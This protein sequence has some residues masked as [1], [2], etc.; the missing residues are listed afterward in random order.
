MLNRA[1]IRV[2]VIGV[3]HLGRH[4]ARIYSQM[5]DAQLVWVADNSFKQRRAIGA[6]TGARAI[7]DYRIGLKEVD[8][9]TIATPTSFHHGIAKVCL[10]A[11][12]HCLVEKPLTKTST[13]AD[14]LVELARRHDRVL[15]VGHIERFNPALMAL[16]DV[17]DNPAFVTSE[18]ISPFSFRSGDV[19]V[20][21]DLMIHDLDIVLTL[22]KSPVIDVEAMG[23]NVLGNAEDL[24]YARLRFKNNCTALF[25]SSRVAWKSLRKIRLFQ[26]SCYISVDYF[27][28]NIYIF[29]K[30]DDFHLG[31]WSPDQ[32][33]VSGIPDLKEFVFS[34][35][36]NVQTIPM[37]QHDPLEKELES[38]LAA[39]R[40][41][42]SP[43]VSGQDGRDA[44]RVAERIIAVMAAHP[45]RKMYAQALREAR[46]VDE[47]NPPA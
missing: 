25:T 16:T 38:F 13:E 24:A 43:V 14:E 35:F 3:G 20:V 17:I 23:I 10:E 36:L 31:S 11:G 30:S 27:D 5:D 29:K 44:I 41:D 33:D 9:V 12:V 21:H 37:N 39:C 26:P 40:G 15:Q 47:P 32:T 22:V 45:L 18:R 46:E 1:K 2:G 28:R 34:K 7:D 8:A 6:K 19:S 4:H 42:H